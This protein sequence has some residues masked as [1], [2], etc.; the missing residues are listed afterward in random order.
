MIRNLSDLPDDLNPNCSK[1]EERDGRVL[2]LLCQTLLEY[3]WHR[4]TPALKD[5]TDGAEL[6][7]LVEC[8]SWSYLLCVSRFTGK[9][10]SPKS[11]FGLLVYLLT[12]PWLSVRKHA[13]ATVIKFNDQKQEL[14][15]LLIQ[16]FF[17]SIKPVTEDK[18][19]SKKVI[20]SFLEL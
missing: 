12:C 6:A 10:P 20:T 11:V 15:E 5:K 13:S 8:F 14:S 3:H 7:H 19:A 2:A 16:S 4:V 1:L 9:D 17:L 18:T